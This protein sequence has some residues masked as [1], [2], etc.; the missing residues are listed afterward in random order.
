MV[1]ELGS[2][3]E[4]AEEQVKRWFQ[5]LRYK[6]RWHKMLTHPYEKVQGAP[7]NHV[8]LETA[9][10]ILDGFSDGC[11]NPDQMQIC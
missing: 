8:I 9:Q 4:I 1:T 6:W 10:S 11:S 5:M 3:F 7:K 2:M